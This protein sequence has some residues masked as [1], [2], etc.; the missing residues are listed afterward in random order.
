M[1]KRCGLAI[2]SIP[3]LAQ[4]RAN[5]VLQLMASIVGSTASNLKPLFDELKGENKKEHTR[6]L[7]ALDMCLITQENFFVGWQKALSSIKN[8]KKSNTR[9]IMRAMKIQPLTPTSAK[10]LGF[11]SLTDA[12]VASHGIAAGEDD[13]DADD[14]L[15]V[16]G[17][18]LLSMHDFMTFGFTADTVDE[19]PE[20]HKL[21]TNSHSLMMLQLTLQQSVL[22]FADTCEKEWRMDLVASINPPEEDDPKKR[23]KVTKSEL[24]LRIPH[25]AKLLNTNDPNIKLYKLPET[26]K[27]VF[28]GAVGVSEKLSL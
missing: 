24:L 14:D 28:F 23:D 26:F 12:A 19:N 11:D 6:S 22:D 10:L 5:Y 18:L 25:D 13:H 4:M 15:P 16:G 8:E 7:V 17:S 9:E 1:V 27:L 3:M 21:L 20:I 2:A